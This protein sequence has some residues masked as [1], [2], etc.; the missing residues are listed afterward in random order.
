MTNFIDANIIVMAFTENPD[1]QN[2]RRFLANFFVTDILCLVE[3]QYGI[4]KITK[5][6]NY[7]TA[8][9][10]S[11]YKLS[12]RIVDLDK[13]LLFEALKGIRDYDLSIYDFIHYTTALQE[14]CSR[15]VSYDKD[16]DDLEIKR[17]EP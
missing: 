15:F 4:T 1:K 11:I 10:K 17:V 13:N 6:K 3:A 12:S 16:F 2:C 8:C 9:I 14:T 5:D 7:S